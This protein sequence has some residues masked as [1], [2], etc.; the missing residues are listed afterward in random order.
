MVACIPKMLVPLYG[1]LRSENVSIALIM[2]MSVSPF[3]S[4]RSENVSINVW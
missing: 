4:L 3:S 1:S 2:K